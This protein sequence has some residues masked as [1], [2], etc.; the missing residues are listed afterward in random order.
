MAVFE[1]INIKTSVNDCM[2]Y[3]QDPEK[4]AASEDYERTMRYMQSHCIEDIGSVG[5]HGCSGNREL[6]VEQFKL[7][8]QRYKSTHKKYQPRH[9]TI[10]VAEYLKSNRKKY[11]PKHLK[12][13]PPEDADSMMPIYDAIRVV[14]STK[15]TEEEKA[16][17]RKVMEAYKVD[18]VKTENIALHGIISF[19]KDDNPTPSQVQSVVN[20]FM[21]HPYLKDFPAL[22]NIHWNTDEKHCHVV[23]SNFSSDGTRK[24][25]LD[26]PKYWELKRHLDKL[27]IEHGFSV[28]DSNGV[29]RDEA[30]AELLDELK[31]A[32][33]VKVRAPRK[34]TQKT[35]QGDSSWKAHD[36]A[37]KKS[38]QSY[39]DQNDKMLPT[40]KEELKDIV[41]ND[42]YQGGGDYIKPT[43]RS[44]TLR[45]MQQ[46]ADEERRR[47]TPEQEAAARR[48]RAK[49]EEQWRRF[50]VVRIYVYDPVTHRRRQ[51][52][53]IELIFI[54]ARII[55]TGETA[56]L[57]SNYPK[58]YKEFEPDFKPNQRI[59]NIIDSIYTTRDFNVRTPSDLDERLKQVGNAIGET[60]QAIRKDEGWLERNQYLYNAIMTWQDKSR[61]EEERKKVYAILAS[62]KCKTEDEQNDFL[63]RYERAKNR[64]PE[65]KQHLEQLNKDYR[66]L[67]N[68]V[69]SLNSV[70]LD[71]QRCHQVAYEA[72]KLKP[73][74]G[75]QIHKAEQKAAQPMPEEL[76]SEW[77]ETPPPTRTQTEESKKNIEWIRERRDKNAS[78]VEFTMARAEAILAE[79]SKARGETYK[80]EDFKDL[81]YLI[82]QT[83]HLEASLQTELD[84]VNNL[85]DRWEKASDLTLPAAERQKHEHYVKW[86]GCDPE[87]EAELEDLRG[88]RELIQLQ[89]QQA[90]SMREALLQTSE[91][92]KGHNSLSNAESNLAWAKQRERELKHKLKDIK[93]NRAKLYDIAMKCDKSARHN[94]GDKE[95]WEKARK[96]RNLCADKVH[97]QKVVEQR[98]KDLKKQKKEAK[99]EIREAKKQANRPAQKDGR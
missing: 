41:R 17:A 94:W 54:L 78:K 4:F 26:T 18:S 15:R 97:E 11:L 5:Y 76:R 86:S 42:L 89:Q 58:R 29:R 65:Q 13:I 37:R 68:A 34:Q 81:N 48:Q 75:A 20:G 44:M 55:I 10:T 74:L 3:I 16:E 49:E 70:N 47:R 79:A 1:T 96:Y 62:N 21:E 98:L 77:K 64:I 93:A 84:K 8:E 67:K 66:R 80:W 61:P 46:L 35:R 59:Q 56:F 50:Y 23:I 7:A 9:K 27:C 63:G 40:V 83:A 6:A 92:W 19:H 91:H 2:S 85:I 43:I 69:T 57:E 30:H 99:R 31:E 32:G 33:T 14:N 72:S 73:E 25:S 88:E 39:Y 52:S 38:W 28:I 45:E 53:L 51:R 90:I 87:E 22:S 60:K 82:S 12:P 71:C 95:K 24:L 36:T